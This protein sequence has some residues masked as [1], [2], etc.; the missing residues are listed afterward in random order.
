MDSVPVIRVRGVNDAPVNREGNYVLYWMIAN[1]RARWNFALQR[2]VEWAANLSKPL[3][4]LEALRRDYHWASE[5]FDRFV[6]AGMRDNTRAFEKHRVSYYP[7]VEKKPGEGRGLL[8]ALA[9]QSCVVVTDEYPCFFLPRMV[10][11]AAGQLPVHLEQVDSTGL[12]PMR[13]ASRYY[14]TAFPFRRFLQKAL[15]AHLGAFPQEDPLRHASLPRLVRLPRGIASRWPRLAAGPQEGGE[16]PRGGAAVARLRLRTFLKKQLAGYEEK[17]NRPE[18]DWSSGL[19]PY[20]HFGHISAHE[21]FNGL[22]RVE[23]WTLNRLG[24]DRSGS[25]TGWWGMSAG[26]EAFLEQLVTWRELGYNACHFRGDYDQYSSLPDW[27]RETLAQHGKDRRAYLYTPAQFESAVTH[28]PLWNAA[29][30]QLVREGRIHNYMRMLWGKKILEWSATPPEALDIMIELNN[31]YALD[32]RDPNSYSG[33]FWIFGRYDRAWGPE[34]PVFGKV[35][36]MSSEN[37]ARKYPVRQYIE[38]YRP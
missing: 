7:Y 23:K 13:M 1:R 38:R 26:A 8:A 17:R 21:I 36:Y 22:R 27:A 30:V 20:L 11:V 16:V 24:R 6:I 14:P 32:G 2:A 37:A 35:R 33:I 3:V 12:L 4:I 5:R 31:K 19:S 25:R 9:D 18:E 15:P 34:R 10:S 28:D 29:Q